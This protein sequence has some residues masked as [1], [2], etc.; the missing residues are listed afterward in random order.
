MQKIE[1]IENKKQQVDQCKFAISQ[2]YE[3]FES[4]K[5]LEN[6]VKDKLNSKHYLTNKD[7]LQ[8]KQEQL[9]KDNKPE[10]KEIIYYNPFETPIEELRNDPLLNNINY[11]PNIYNH[12]EQFYFNKRYITKIPHQL[13]YKTDNYSKSFYEYMKTTGSFYYPNIFSI[14]DTVVGELLQECLDH[15]MNYCLRQL[16]SFV[17]ELYKDELMN[18][19]YIK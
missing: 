16:D 14:Y 3:N 2:Y 7:I 15:E 11:N 1:E 17:T 10:R 8:I 19:E 13:L 5:N 18:N 9:S 12:P 4:M 6:Q